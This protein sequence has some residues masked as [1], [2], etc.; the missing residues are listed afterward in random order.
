MA[1]ATNMG[2][3]ALWI[4]PL[5][6]VPVAFFVAIP[7]LKSISHPVA[8]LVTAGAVIFAM[9]YASYLSFRAQRGLDEVQKAG[10]AFAAQWG[11]PAGQ[12]AFGLLL[13]LPPFKDFATA[14]V[15]KFA[16]H[17]AASVDGTV[18]VL[19]LAL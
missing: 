18:V 13:V 7:W 2:R 15:S 3:G 9:S 16:V 1:T 17:P 4:L 5:V 14:V 19:S 11:A 6:A 8:I 12:V 10:A